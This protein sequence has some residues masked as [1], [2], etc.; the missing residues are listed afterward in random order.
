VIAPDPMTLYVTRTGALKS[1]VQQAVDRCVAGKKI[2][3]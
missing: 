1:Q 3:D 2:V